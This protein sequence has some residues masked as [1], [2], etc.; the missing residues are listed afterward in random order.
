MKYKPG[1]TVKIKTPASHQW[2]IGHVLESSGDTIK[3]K[4]I[5]KVKGVDIWVVSASNVKQHFDRRDANMKGAPSL[6]REICKV[7]RRMR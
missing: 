7:T 5:F 3:V 2:F 6:Q 1:D 4:T